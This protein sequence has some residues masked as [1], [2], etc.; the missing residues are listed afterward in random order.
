MRLEPLCAA[1]RELFGPRLGFRSVVDG[2]LPVLRD[3]VEGSRAWL[4]GDPDHLALRLLSAA[5]DAALEGMGRRGEHPGAWATASSEVVVE[6]RGLRLVLLQ[7]EREVASGSVSH[8]E[9]GGSP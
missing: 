6:A 8:Q 9:E 1:L 4:G 2:Q 3:G 7:G 5:H